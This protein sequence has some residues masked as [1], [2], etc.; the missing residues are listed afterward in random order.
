MPPWAPLNAAPTSRLLAGP[1][2]TP[3]FPS[4]HCAARRRPCAPSGYRPRAWSRR[5]PAWASNAAR[6]LPARLRAG[7]PGSEWAAPSSAGRAAARASALRELT[8]GNCL[9]GASTARAA[10]FAAGR[11]T[12]QHRGKPGRARVPADSCPPGEPVRLASRTVDVGAQRRPPTAER[13]GPPTRSLARADPTTANASQ[14]TKAARWATPGTG[15]LRTSVRSRVSCV[16]GR[17]KRGGITEMTDPQACCFA[18]S[19]PP[20]ETQ[21]LLGAARRET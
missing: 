7:G 19:L 11:G 9:S 16:A 5:C 12:E 2:G 3:G 15:R 14:A 21:A 8:R 20:G 1:A 18:A 17:A 4:L 13:T 6:R 10:S